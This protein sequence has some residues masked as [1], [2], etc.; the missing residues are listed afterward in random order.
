DTD[1]YES[2]LSTN[3]PQKC[4]LDLNITLVVFINCDPLASFTV[5]EV[6]CILGYLNRGACSDA[7]WVKWA[8]RVT[9]GYYDGSRPDVDFRIGT[10]LG[11]RLMTSHED[12]RTR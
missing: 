3:R 11:L 6:K 7:F 2:K 9:S 1:S 10:G 4:G 5:A 12:K 8:G